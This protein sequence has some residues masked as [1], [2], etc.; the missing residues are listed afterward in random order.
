MTRLTTEV[1]SRL[2][3]SFYLDINYFR[4]NFILIYENNISTDILYEIVNKYKVRGKQIHDANIVAS[5]LANDIKFL[6]THNVKD[7]DR[8][9][10]L[11]SIIPLEIK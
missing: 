3:D 9:K 11:I 4:K 6:F 5:M 1:D 7:F 2:I 8:Y 10:E